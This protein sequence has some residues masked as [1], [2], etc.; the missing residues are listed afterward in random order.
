[1]A[2]RSPVSGGHVTN[3]SRRFQRGPA[4]AC[5]RSRI[6]GDGFLNIPR[7][8]SI[9][10]R[11]QADGGASCRPAGRR[12]RRRWDSRGL[13]LRFGSLSNEIR[14]RESS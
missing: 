5:T 1:M 8:P 12:R 4:R 6:A 9:P 7:A 10:R 14:A 2:A 13:V 3:R 11:R